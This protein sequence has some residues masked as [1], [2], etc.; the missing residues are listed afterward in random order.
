ME[1][2]KEQNIKKFEEVADGSHSPL[3][4]LYGGEKV[5]LKNL[6][7]IDESLSSIFMLA[8]EE[9]HE[10]LDEYEFEEL[11]KKVTGN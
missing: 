1:K 11:E 2:K 9:T 5:D 4:N 7:P 8:K 3:Q 6:R 10:E